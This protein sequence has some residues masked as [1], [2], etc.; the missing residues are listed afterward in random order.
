[1]NEE[2]FAYQLP[3]KQNRLSS[4]WIAI[5]TL[6]DSSVLLHGYFNSSTIVVRKNETVQFRVPHA[7]LPK[8]LSKLKTIGFQSHKQII[9]RRKFIL[10]RPTLYCLLKVACCH[11][12]H[13]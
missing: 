7:S 4:H 3:F 12:I 9:S 1:M 10:L 11:Y 5:Q 6:P 2:T 8:N 13:S